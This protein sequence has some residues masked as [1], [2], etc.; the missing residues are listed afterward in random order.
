MRKTHRVLLLKWEG[1]VQ[2]YK[3]VVSTSKR[4]K[5]PWEKGT[6]AEAGLLLWP[7]DKLS[8]VGTCGSSGS[9]ALLS[10]SR[11]SPVLWPELYLTPASEEQQEL[12]VGE[13]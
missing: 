2:K 4:R 7:R 1:Q 5:A 11:P 9:W 12:Q 10:I 13:E 6:Q 3:A 8:E